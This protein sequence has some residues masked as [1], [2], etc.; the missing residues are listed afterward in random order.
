MDWK[1]IVKITKESL[2]PKKVQIIQPINP[3]QITSLEPEQEIVSWKIEVPPFSIPKKILR[4][5][6]VLSVMFSLF[7]ILNQEWLYL[8]LVLSLAFFTNVIISYGSKTLNYTIYS[9]GV[10]LN[11]SFYTWNKFNYFFQYEGDNEMIV[12]TTKEMFPGRLYVYVKE[13]EK[14]KIDNTLLN[15]IP[16]NL[17]H[18]KDFYEVILFKIR[19]YINL[20]DDK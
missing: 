1:N 4:T 6:I 10:K 13:S 11:D 12:I 14:N 20:S 9:N 18:P 16:K 8:I 19:P 7:L 17:V 2:E 5:V 15:Y 3:P